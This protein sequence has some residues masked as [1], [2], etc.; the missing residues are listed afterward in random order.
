[1]LNKTKIKKLDKNILKALRINA[2]TQY[3]V[4]SMYSGE[5]SEWANFDEVSIF[6]KEDLPDVLKIVFK[7]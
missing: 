6:M 3:L 2:L 1:M 5:L 7:K 4:I